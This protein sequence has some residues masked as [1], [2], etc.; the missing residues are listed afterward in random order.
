MSGKPELTPVRDHHRFDEAALAAYM[1]DHMDGDF[2]SLNVSQFEGGQSNPTFLVQAGDDSYVMRKK[3]PGTLLKSA[4]AVDR[5]HRIMTALQNTG[6]PVPKTYT[7]CED[8][9]I[10]GTAFFLMENVEGRVIPDDALPGLTPADRTTLYEHFA[11]VLAALH[12]V[13]YNAIGLDGFGREGNYFARQIS[14]WSKQYIASQT[15]D[16]ASMNALMEWL[17]ENIPESD[18]QSIAHGD[19][20][21]GNC[22]IHPTEPRVV[23]LLDW[24][25]STIGHPLGDLGYCCMSYHRMRDGVSFPEPG[26]GIP[27]EKE[28][29]DLYCK[30]AG[31]GEIENW[32]FYISYNLFRS[33]AIVQGVYKRGLDGNASSER[34][35]ETGEVCKRSAEIAWKLAQEI[36]A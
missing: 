1:S 8:D 26:S 25:L 12:A 28:F 33:A 36:G 21:I 24:E 23:A 9:S 19:Y 7:L 31:R 16:L 29:V 30:A 35:R 34:W 5:E 27:L 13:D 17:P 18:D 10:I 2:A 3:P 11:E 32:N 14:R 4:H 22:V 15:E 20:R 6:V